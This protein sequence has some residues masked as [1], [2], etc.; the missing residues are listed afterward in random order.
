MTTFH[1]FRRSKKYGMWHRRVTMG[2]WQHVW[3]LGSIPNSLLLL[4][5]HA[6][7]LLNFQSQGLEAKG[8]G[9]LR[10]FGIL[11]LISK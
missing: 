8:R 9:L 6:K 4:Q 10:N 1:G 11:H 7:E 2:A 3:S 5:Q